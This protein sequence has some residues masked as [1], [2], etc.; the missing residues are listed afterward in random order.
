MSLGEFE[1]I[2][3]YFIRGGR[4]SDI[5]LGI[6][7]DAAVLEARPGRKL[8]VAMDTIVEGVH[9]PIDTDAADIGYRALVVNLSDIAAMGAE[10]AWMT[11]SLSLPRA[12]E[13]WLSGFAAGLFGLADQHGVALAG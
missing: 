12:N 3:R 13:E 10:P 11:L 2:E 5:L 1:I 7:D 9:F 8:V 4:Q 6:G